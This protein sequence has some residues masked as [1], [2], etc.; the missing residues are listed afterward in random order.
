[1]PATVLSVWTDLHLSLIH[2]SNTE[3][4]GVGAWLELPYDEAAKNQVLERLGLELFS[5]CGIAKIHAAAPLFEQLAGQDHDIDRWNHLAKKLASMTEKELLKYKAV[6][7]FEGCSS[8]EQ[9]AEL[10]DML[11]PV[12]YTHLAQPFYGGGAG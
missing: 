11:E 9:A 7:E 5:H 10:T 6:S 4:L 2:I 12:S 3:D 8:I 1:M